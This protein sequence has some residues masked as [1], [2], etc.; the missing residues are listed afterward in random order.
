[1][2]RSWTV[3]LLLAIASGAALAFSFPNYDLPLLAWISVALLMLAAI[4]ARMRKAA[5]YGFLSGALFYPL[6]V[7]WIDTVMQQ[8]GN[9]PPLPAAGILALVSVAG[10]FLSLVFAVLVARV[11]KSSLGM[12]CALAPFL[13]VVLEFAR[14]HLPIIG[15]PWN[16]LG[17]ATSGNLALVQLTTLTGIYGLSWLVAAF[18]ALLVWALLS[19]SK[20]SRVAVLIATATLILIAIV[21]PHFVPSAHADHVAHLVQTNFPQASSYPSDWMETHAADMK[22]LEAISI[23]A[24]RKEPGLIV[25]PEV[26]APFSLQDQKFAAVAEDIAHLSGE[27]FGESFLVGVDDWKLGPDRQWQA[28]NSAVLLGPTGRREFTYDKIH[29]VPFGEYVPLRKWLTFAQSLV[30]GIGDFTPGHEYG[31]GRLPGGQFSVYICYEAIF[32]DLVRRFTAKGAGL[33]INISND[34]WFGHEAAPAQHLIMARV[35][36][37]ENRRWV[38]R[39]TNTG[40]TVDVDPYGRTV[41]QLAPY[42]R[43]ELDAPYSFRTDLTP[44]VRWGDWLAWLSILMVVLLLAG[45]LVQRGRNKHIHS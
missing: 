24:A 40:F 44:Y 15:F 38:L 28:S 45:D 6:S 4:G 18:N 43:G 5:L 23:E 42:I 7:P 2:K 11:A 12:A 21:G 31:V 32:P 41:A 10:G 20:R 14:T 1:M 36:A 37:V 30:A 35:R 34:G 22:Q 25:W 9:V 13:W 27:D 29:L 19:P 16:L 33:L 17:Y 8:Y 26:P 3:R 39:C